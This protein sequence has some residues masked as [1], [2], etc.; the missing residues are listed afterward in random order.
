MLGHAGVGLGLDA[1]ARA[2]G[3]VIK[4]TGLRGSLR[5]LEE[6]KLHSRL[7]RLVVIGG[8]EEHRVRADLAGIF[9]QLDSVCD[10]VRARARDN[11]NS[12]RNALN[13]IFDRRL[14]LG[15]VKGRAL[16]RGSDGN[17]RVDAVFYLEINKLTEIFKVDAGFGKWFTPSVGMRVGYSGFTTRLWADN[18]SVLGS[19]LD[20]DKD[21]YL[22]K[23]GYMYVHGDFLCD[24]PAHAGFPAADPCAGHSD[25]G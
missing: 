21:M 10:I 24:H 3:H 11:G 9:C 23:F 2:R 13:A 7:S 6:G 16:A 22:Q 18:P 8:D 17:E 19:E 12:A 25:A 4:D 20:K 14:V 1:A 5:D 15:I